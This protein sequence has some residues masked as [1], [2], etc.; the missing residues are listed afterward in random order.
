LI[1]QFAQDF[2]AELVATARKRLD[3]SKA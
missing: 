1:V 2:P 3:D